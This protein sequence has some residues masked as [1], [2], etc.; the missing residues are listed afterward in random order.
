M[1]AAAP[2]TPDSVFRLGS[3]TKQLTAATVLKLIEDG[4]ISLDDPV[5][6]FFP[7]YPQPGGSATVRQLLNHTS[8]IVSYTDVPGWMV[9]ANTNRAY[10]TDQMVALFR[11]LP[12]R[13]PPGQ[14]WAYNNSGYVLLAAIVERVTGQRWHQVVEER[15]TRPL[16]LNTI[17]Y[18]ADHEAS[19][20]MVRGYTVTDG[21]V[22]ASRPTH[23]SVPH[24]AGGLV[25]SVGDFARWTDALHH[26]RVVSPALYAEMI[27][28]T[29]LPDGRAQPY[30]FGLATGEMRGRRVIRHDGRI[31]GFSTEGLYLPDQD[32]FVAVFA[33]SDRPATQPGLLARRL[34]A[35]A[36]GVP[37]RRFTQTAVDPAVVAPL[38]GV[39]RVGSSGVSRR[40]FAR[41]GKLYAAR[42]EGGPEREVLAAGGDEFFYPDSF[43]W[44]RIERRPDA[45]PVMHMHQDDSAAAE[46]AVRVVEAPQ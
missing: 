41:D 24:A 27:A 45:E 46:L 30:G 34:A 26:G 13:T 5:S 28:P 2:I 23:R 14:A 6:R 37:Y 15:V 38:L 32:V 25:G 31:A 35:L 1:E 21:A 17:G 18:G 36:V 4:R 42:A 19:P 7:D 3:L 40:F 22:R 44:F 9:E 11:D 33:N 8:G 20:A 10:T 29:S 16:G 39:Y 43:T 12:S